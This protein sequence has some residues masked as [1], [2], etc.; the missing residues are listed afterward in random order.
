ME[1]VGGGVA[2]AEGAA[3]D[4]AVGGDEAAVVAGGGGVEVDGCV[5][6]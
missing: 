4:S 1:A 6:E 2:G 5:C 3:I